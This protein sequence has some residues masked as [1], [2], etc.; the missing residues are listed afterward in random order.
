MIKHATVQEAHQ[1]QDGGSPY[2]DVRSIP[3]FDQAHPAGAYNVPLF[4]VDPGTRQMRPNQKFVAVMAANFA[5]DTPLLLGCAAG[6]RSV[7]AAQL[8]ERAGFTNLT[9]VLGGFG[10]SPMGDP[11]WVHAGL[12]VA[13]SPDTGRDYAALEQKPAPSR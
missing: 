13:T 12:P 1:Q 10:G 6:V 8:L 4:H 9:N 7:Q 11:G 5:P 3:E 2:V